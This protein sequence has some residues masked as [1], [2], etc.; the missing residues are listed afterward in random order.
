MKNQIV[1]T[2]LSLAALNVAAQDVVV[3]KDGSTILAKVL[4]VN[5]DNIK[6]KKFS[7]QNGPTYTINLSDVMSVNYENGEKEDFN[8]SSITNNANQGNEAKEIIKDAAPNNSELLNLYAKDYHLN[9]SYKLKDKETSFG[10]AFLSFSNSSILSNDEIEIYLERDQTQHPDN[11]MFGTFNANLKSSPLFRYDI[12]FKNKTSKI[13]YVDLANCFRTTN[14]GVSYCYYSSDIVTENK[15]STSGG[16]FNLGGITNAAGIGGVAGSLA[17]ATTVGK[18]NS[19]SLSKTHINQR[20]LQIPPKG[21]VCLSKFEYV[22]EKKATSLSFGIYELINQGEEFFFSDQV[23]RVTNSLKLESKVL[24]LKIGSV[25]MGE[26]R[27]FNIDDSPFVVNYHLVYSTKEDFSTYSVLSPM[28]YINKIIGLKNQLTL[29]EWCNEDNLK[30][31]IQSFGEYTIVGPIL[32][33]K[34]KVVKTG[35]LGAF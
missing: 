30:E 19:T 31:I 11:T 26:E 12:V 9:P 17:N 22:T 18:S 16:S 21:K 7:N 3:K 23:D 28:L 10:I 14:L 4:E 32:L 13:I 1:L 8:N 20:I 5:Q 29:R 6:Y 27:R 35:L 33:K 2:M 15:Q 25:K 24:P 34:N